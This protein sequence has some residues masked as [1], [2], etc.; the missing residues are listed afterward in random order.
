MRVHTQK[1]ITRKAAIAAAV[2]GATLILPGAAVADHDPNNIRN[3]YTCD[4]AVP[5]DCPHFEASFFVRVQNPVKNQNSAVQL[6]FEQPDRRMPVMRADYYLPAGWRF[7]GLSTL[8][9]SAHATC[10]AAHNASG[11]LQQTELLSADTGMLLQV[12]GRRVDDPTSE[13]EAINAVADPLLGPGGNSSAIEYGVRNPGGTE[14]NRFPSVSFLNWNPVGGVD[15]LGEATLCYHHRNNSSFNSVQTTFIQE[16]KLT[17]ISSV[18]G[19]DWRLSIDVSSVMKD[20]EA[21]NVRAS[22]LRHHLALGALTA[23]NWHR[24]PVT[25]EFQKVPFSR[26]PLSAGPVTFRADLFTCADGLNQ[27]H[28]TGCDNGTFVGQT[29]TKVIDITPAPDT[30]TFDWGKLSGPATPG[31]CANAVCPLGLVRGTNSLNVTWNQPALV[32]DQE[33][34]GYALTIAK[35]GNEASRKFYRLITDPVTPG[36]NAAVCG[37]AGGNPSCSFTINLP[38][39]ST[40]GSTTLLASG[41]YHL[42]L[43]TI[44]SD[45]RR[46]DQRCDETVPPLTGEGVD[47]PAGTPRLNVKPEPGISSWQVLVRPEAWPVAFVETWDD[48]NNATFDDYTNRLLLVDFALKEAELVIWNTNDDVTSFRAVSNGIIGDNA[49]GSGV[50]EINNGTNAGATQNWVLAAVAD[51]IFGNA[52]GTFARYDIKNPG[53]NPPTLGGW[54]EL[55]AKGCE[56]VDCFVILA[57][58]L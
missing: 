13:D 9:A 50:I 57:G 3:P 20:P 33:I 43:V 22:I 40:D 48:T 38:V 7:G 12:D 14:G 24:H 41:K 39:Q 34:R 51:P 8:D 29:L 47:C 45:G 54:P 10:V 49:S 28:A 25:N 36:F 27:A 21:D 17:R 18:P 6:S 31:L 58:A 15:G 23:G 35:P 26:T 37:P 5:D 46:T 42:A 52:T 30:T 19:F 4:P 16:A 44:Y 53:L 11:Q 55:G 32:G 1:R 56:T 2:L